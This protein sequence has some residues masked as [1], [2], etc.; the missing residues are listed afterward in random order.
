MT[1]AAAAAR[2]RDARPLPRRHRLPRQHLP[3]PD[4]RGRADRAARGRRAGGPGRGATAA[5]WAAGTSATRW[6]SARPRSLTAAGY[7]ATR[8]RARQID[9]GWTDAAT[10]Y[11]LLLAMDAGHRRELL[12]AGADPDRV[13]MFRDFDPVDPGGDVPDPY[14]GGPDAAS[15][16]CWRWWSAHLRCSPR[17][18]LLAAHGHADLGRPAA[19]DPSARGRPARRGPA[20]LGGGRH[21]AGRRR[22]HLHRHQAAALRRTTALMKTHPHAPP[23]FF[24]VE[25]RRAALA[26]RGP[27]AGGVHVPE[28]LGRRPRVPH[29][30]LGRAG[31]AHRRRRGRLRR[32]ARGHPRGRAPSYGGRPAAYGAEPHDGF[33]GRLPLPG[34]PAADL[35][36]VL[37]DPA[38]AALP[39]ARPR[40]RPGDRRGRRGDRGRRSAGSPSWCPRSR[41]LACTATCGTATSL[42]G[43]EGRG[44]VI[45]PAAHG[46]HRETDLAMLA[47]FGL[48]HLARVLEAYDAG[49]PPGGGLGV[50]AGTPPAVPAAGARLH[51]RRRVRRP[52]GGDSPPAYALTET[53][54]VARMRGRGVWD[55]EGPQPSPAVPPGAPPPRKAAHRHQSPRMVWCVTMMTCASQVTT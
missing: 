9:R 44:W 46:G 6:T 5:A 53:P 4:R 38:G 36:G 3:L 30:A 45:D 39:Q 41:R 13:R 21:G 32:G 52:R 35:G 33:I 15:R 22:R 16:R 31:Q 43:A 40:P 10:G 23:E 27:E 19:D 18:Q 25:A 48:P 12:A 24:E 2:R 34:K 8:H 28:V 42:W 7:D 29:P 50:A 55:P 1:D 49:R 17:S 11:D 20:R 37:R 54:S 26:G 47:L 51:V 14:Y